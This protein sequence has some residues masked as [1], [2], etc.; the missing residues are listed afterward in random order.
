MKKS[1][2]IH[3][4]VGVIKT[5]DRHVLISKRHVHLHQG[6]LWEFPGGKVDADETVQQAL[7]RELHEELGIDVVKSTPLIQI[8]YDYGDKHV[9]LDVH[10]VPEYTG[11]A[12]GKEEQELRIV[13][14]SEL[15]RYDFPAANRGIVS[16]IQL[17]RSYMITRP[18][19]PMD[20]LMSDIDRAI[21]DG[22]ELIQYR[23]HALAT[24][25]YATRIRLISMRCSQRNVILIANTPVENFLH[26]DVSG[27]HL[28]S[29][30]LLAC[31]KRP[32]A[33]TTWFGASVHDETQLKHA[34]EIKVDYVL[35][36]PVKLTG[37]HPDSTPIGWPG[38]QSLA[39]MSSVPVY[40]L[41]GMQID[42]LEIAIQ[43]GGQGIA[44][45][46]LFR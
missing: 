30:R 42:D 27:L 3:V 19:L 4:A 44:G 39:K 13:P 5:D 18:S 23:D 14:V 41:G 21:A 46:S 15:H 31:R 17:P 32:V 43:S 1:Q 26:C 11:A 40:A 25:E 28:T 33:K 34:L 2:P 36:S 45:I 22:V 8:P 6:G 24:D 9:L 20:E 7:S 12:H 35:L 38:F 16:A 10:V 37:S 29:E